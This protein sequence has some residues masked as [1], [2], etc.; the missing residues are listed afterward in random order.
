MKRGNLQ[1]VESP[2]LPKSTQSWTTENRLRLGGLVTL[3]ILVIGFLLVYAGSTVSNSSD[4]DGIFSMKIGSTEVYVLSDGQLT[5]NALDWY[6][7]VSEVHI[8]TF[9]L[10]HCIFLISICLCD[11]C[12]C[13]NIHNIHT[14]ELVGGEGSSW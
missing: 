8:D 6:P 9:Y 12:V 7:D 11:P 14:G 5:K 2:L 13:T 10:I 3:V 4:T 1:T